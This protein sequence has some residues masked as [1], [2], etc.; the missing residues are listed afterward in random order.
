MTCPQMPL[1]G[2][3]EFLVRFNRKVGEN[4]V[5]LCGTLD[6]TH[7]CNLDCIHCYLGPHRG[8]RHAERA[9]MSTAQVLSVIDQVTAA[10][11]LT[12]LI[13]GGEPLLRPDFEQVYRHA[14]S[15]GL[16][17]SL[18][19]N[20]TLVSEP[21]ADLLAE[22]PPQMVE[23]TL[24]G[25]TA[26]TYEHI[27][28]VPGS[29]QRCLNGVRRLAE[30][31]V[32][33][34]LKTVLMTANVREYTAIRDLARQMGLGFRY[35]AA[36]FPR[37]NG[38]RSPLALRVPPQEVVRLEMEGEGA[39]AEWR[40]YYER[41]RDMPVSDRL[42][43]CGAG[44]TS[45]HIDACGRL[46]PCVMSRDYEYDLNEGSFVDGWNGVMAQIRDRRASP[47]FYCNRCQRRVLCS[48]CPPFSRAENGNEQVP[49]KY[50]CAI[51][52]LRYD[53]LYGNSGRT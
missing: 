1:T 43:N 4:R 23:V 17:V 9:E 21:V 7:R 50:L 42:Y 28:Q 27:A 26:R 46:H 19:T 20:G 39:L 49:S 29:F 18:F 40:E 32:K 12:L 31:R 5:P 34:N 24:Y 3:Q 11:C 15:S 13:T 2:E 38:D 6:L 25:A 51:G 53:A 45:F 52:N 44:L 48:L 14:R 22:L 41:R 30:R 47:F 8:K 16:L 36:I 37:W 33:L 10:G 35:D